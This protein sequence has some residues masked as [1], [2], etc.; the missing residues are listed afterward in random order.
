MLNPIAIRVVGIQWRIV[1][2]MGVYY[3]DKDGVYFDLTDH[4]D[5]E[6]ATGTRIEVGASSR[7][8]VTQ[9]SEALDA[10][11]TID[12]DG[13][14]AIGP[15]APTHTSTPW[16]TTSYTDGEA[17]RRA[18]IVVTWAEPNNTDSSTVTDGSHYTVRWRRQ[19]DTD[20]SYFQVPWGTEI[21]VVN[22]LAPGG[23]FEIS[24]EA[25]D[26][27][28]NRS[29]YAADEVVTA[30]A[31]TG[32][33]STPAAPTVAGNT[34]NVQVSHDLT[35]SGG[36]D[37]ED[38]LDHLVTYGDTSSGFTPSNANR[39]GKIQANKAHIDLGI[40]V[41]GTFPFEDTTTRYF[42]VT[43]VNK[44][45][46]E[47]AKSAEAT[48]SAAL[49]DTQHITDLAVQTAKIA[50]LAVDT[51]KIALL[52][53]DTAQIANLAVT[54]AQIADLSAAKITAGTINAETI[55]LGTAGGNGA[56]QSG[57]F[58][59]GSAGFQVLGDGSVEFNDGTFRG[60]ITIT[61]GTGIVVIDDGDWATDFASVSLNRGFT[62]PGIV[63]VNGANNN[64][65]LLAPYDTSASERAAISMYGDATE[66]G[67]NAGNLFLRS[68][69]SGEVQLISGASVITLDDTN[70]DM[71]G[72]WQIERIDGDISGHLI[73]TIDVT[74]D[75]GSPTQVWANLYFGI[76]VAT[77]RL[78]PKTDVTSGMTIGSST[79]RWYEAY[80]RIFNANDGLAA[81]PTYTFTSDPDTGMFLFDT[82][83]LGFATAALN[84]FLIGSY[85]M[86]VDFGLD[87]LPRSDNSSQLGQSGLRY[88]DVW[89][90]DGSINTSDESTKKFVKPLQFEA[91]EF[92]HRV[93]A[94]QFKRKDGGK[95]WH[96]GWSAQAIKGAMDKQGTEWA[97]FVDPSHGPPRGRKIEGPDDDRFGGALGLRPQELVPVLW[98]AWK[99]TD[100]DVIGLKA[101]VI[102]LRAEIEALKEAA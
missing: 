72:H 8:L 3:R 67:S 69:D 70:L 39:L 66:A 38:D 63:G 50:D 21:A 23:I 85:G 59:A 22:N 26:I 27:N 90:V 28:G 31:Q 13:N 17:V 47:S 86:K 100:D 99:E 76:G 94:I 5:W 7:N 55:T 68:G 35:K 12:P 11:I 14:D 52:A 42:V 73:P 54:N 93:Q 87:I 48:V 92:A 49:I 44:A 65:Q 77:A 74:Y 24:V 60:R 6:R 53:V 82:N 95:R 78:E 61:D 2:G 34:L 19:G 89:A 33:P 71:F 80:A 81:F 41:I 36:G 83:E 15:N 40:T 56:I 98:D 1:D 10:R 32:V 45:G 46:G 43:A 102:E 64:L 51:A 97:A 75:L 30:D 9:T 101:E 25:E 58:S 96:V 37:L 62:F 4:V 57:N 29:G 84:R 79:K 20:Y 18:Q 88:I 91:R 16:A